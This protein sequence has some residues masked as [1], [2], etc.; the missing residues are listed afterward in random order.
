MQNKNLE[1]APWNAL[2]PLRPP[3]C[4]DTCFQS[5][6]RPFSPLGLPLASRPFR[7]LYCPGMHWTAPVSCIRRATSPSFTSFRDHAHA[8]PFSPQHLDTSERGAP[9]MILMGLGDR[10]RVRARFHL[11]RAGILYFRG[12]DGT[13]HRGIQGQWSFASVFAD[14]ASLFFYMQVAW[15]L[16]NDVRMKRS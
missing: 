12:S 16:C 1:C 11:W 9:C 2:R 14:T 13:L 10:P 15:D 5:L 8:I 4:P 6:C 3:R 7:W